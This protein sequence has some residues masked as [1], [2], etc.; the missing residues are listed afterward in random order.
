MDTIERAI[1]G[2]TKRVVGTLTLPSGAK[3]GLELPVGM[4]PEDVIDL[5][6]RIPV[7]VAQANQR[8]VAGH[9]ALPNGGLIPIV[10][11]Q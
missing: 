3:V 1:A 10:K 9:V 11:E 5:I 6:V 7:L 8:Q 4:S 2:V